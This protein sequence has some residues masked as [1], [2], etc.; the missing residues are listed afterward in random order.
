MSR[1][2]KT[3]TTPPATTQK[4]ADLV[5]LAVEPEIMNEIECPLIEVLRKD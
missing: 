4:R 1:N 3:E 2:P 5:Y